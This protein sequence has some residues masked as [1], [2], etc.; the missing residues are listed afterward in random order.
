MNKIIGLT[1]ALAAVCA[2]S[3]LANADVHYY[4]V[5]SVATKSTDADLRA[6]AHEL[7]KIY[8]D[9]ERQSGV[10]AKLVWSTNPDVNAFATEVGGEKIV[11]V[12]EGLLS[13]MNGDR[14]AVA[15]VAHSDGV[16]S[17]TKRRYRFRRHVPKRNRGPVA[18]HVRQRRLLE[19]LKHQCSGT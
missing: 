11:V 4:L 1:M 3:P 12:Q 14:D 8:A 6:E 16:R 10:D 19:C 18:R 17:S 9:M 5:D 7:E 2:L 13:M 15:N